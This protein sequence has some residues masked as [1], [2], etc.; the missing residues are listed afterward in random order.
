MFL[1]ATADRLLD[2][3]LDIV[4]RHVL[5]TCRDDRGAQARVHCRVRRAELGSHGDFTRQL[6]EHL[7]LLGVLP[8]LAV[9]NVLEL[10]MSRHRS[11]RFSASAI[12]T[13]QG[14]PYRTRAHAIKEPAQYLS[15]LTDD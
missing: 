12:G 8:P 14:R 7:R 2:G 5:L 3:A 15:W 4:L 6:A 1:V 10:G 11:S 13:L 9:H